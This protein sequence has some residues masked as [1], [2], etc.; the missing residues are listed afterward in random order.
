MML[1]LRSFALLLTLALLFAVAGCGG[2]SAGIQKPD[3]PAPLPDPSTRIN[4]E[5]ENLDPG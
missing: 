4:G 2:S 5:E 1:L 3:N